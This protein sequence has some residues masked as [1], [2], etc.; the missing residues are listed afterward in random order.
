MTISMIKE[1]DKPAIITLEREVS[2][3]EMLRRISLFAGVFATQRGDKVV[4]L[5]ENREGWIYA[6]YSVWNNKGIVVPV[7]ASSTVEDVTYVVEDC[8][9]ACIWASY[10]RA[11]IAIA[12]VKAAGADIPVHIIEDYEHADIRGCDRADVVADSNDVAL[13]M[14]TSG[15]TGS[16]KGVMLSFG[17]CMANINSVAFEVPIFSSFR[18]TLI[19]L[20][21]H[22]ILPLMGTL[23][24][25]MIIGGGVAISPSMSGPDIMA[26]MQKG[27]VAIFIGVPRLWQTLITAILYKI[28][29]K[30]ITKALYN[31]CRKLQ[32]RWLSRTIFSSVRKKMGGNITYCVSGGAALDREIAVA[33]KTIGLDLLEGYGMTECAP[34]IAFTRPDDIIPGSVGKPLPSDKVEIRNGEIFVKGPNIMLGYYNRPEE[35]RE[36]LDSDGWLRTGDLGTFDDHGRLYITGRSKEL[37]VLPN[38]KNVQPY[39]IEF[40][41]EHYDQY[42]K[43]AA[44]VQD[45][46]LLRA[47]IVPQPA[48]AADLSDEE[49]EETLKREVLEPYNLTVV[50]YKKLMS[51]F[52][53]RGDLPRT[54]LDKLQRFK[55]TEIINAGVH[56]APKEKQYVEPAFEEYRVIKQYIRQE[57]KCAVRP[58]DHL[59][60]DLAFDSLDK[61]G[62]QGFIEQTFGMEL[63]LDRM[64]TFRNITELAEYVSDYKTR[65]EFEKTD[66]HSI[67][68]ESSANVKLPGTSYLGVLI[69]KFCR[70]AF[71]HY[72]NFKMIGRENIPANGPFILAANHESYL[73]GMFVMSAVPNKLIRHTYFVAK[74]K[75]VTRPATV[76]LASKLNVI[77]LHM[78]N[79][80][81]SI[82]QLG[83]VL[84]RGES[85]IIFPEGTRT[86]TGKLGEFKKTFAILSVELGVPVI[87]VTIDGA[88]EAMPKHQKM[89]SCGNV[90]VT[91]HKPILPAGLDYDQLCD[92]TKNAVEN[93]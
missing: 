72:F 69:T 41:I 9:P 87:P 25:P 44:V 65:I 93:N 68:Q 91:I 21:L 82:Q 35:T 39:E 15:T 36:V 10:K 62:L 60:T 81:T 27:K 11:E 66:W 59:E 80:K 28:K 79:L 8:T 52:V 38:G 13:I 43:E 6:A 29:S 89:P 49:V 23:M 76:Y 5:S 45:G 22:H 20:P 4:I 61:I 70:W 55:L 26:T 1:L 67:L 18:R 42:V 88:Y 57:K 31:M 16:P 12:A 64:T 2:F 34:I 17:N 84:K 83:E 51:L 40:K 54:K 53:Y 48:W 50:N 71:K 58:T 46:Q 63:P 19:L 73:D 78:S 74:E 33:M 90:S 86:E 3:E 47:I 30:W 77:V 32:W 24:A 7:D 14:Y 75:H 37:I 85:I 92:S 56:T